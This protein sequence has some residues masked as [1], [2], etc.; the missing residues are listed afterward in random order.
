M[1]VKRI[2]NNFFL[3][4]FFYATASLEVAVTDSVSFES[5]LLHPLSLGSHY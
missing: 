2:F 3:Q 4:C 5:Q 1:N